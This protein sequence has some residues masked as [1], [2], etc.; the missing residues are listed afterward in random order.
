M[1]TRTLSVGFADLVGFASTA[2]G[3]SNEDV[4]RYLQG[5]YDAAG[6]AVVS[7]GGSIVKYIGDG[8]VFTCESPTAAVEAARELAAHGSLPFRV[9]VATGSVV[10]AEVGHESMRGIDVFGETVNRAA[11]LL[12]DARASEDGIA[13]C[14]RTRE[15]G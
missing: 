3:M 9:A 5:A 8:V 12:A 11:R 1:E 4:V 7:R 10:V 6:E 13:L 14:E 2:A 15:H